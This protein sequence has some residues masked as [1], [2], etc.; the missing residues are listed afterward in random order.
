M[1]IYR[2]QYIAAG[3][4]LVLT[5]ANKGSAQDVPALPVAPRTSAFEVDRPPVYPPA[6]IPKPPIVFVPPN[7]PQP[8]WMPSPLD[9][10]A[11]ARLQPKFVEHKSRSW[12]WR[13]FQGKVGGYP[14][15]F[16][17]RPFGSSLH[18]HGRMMV[19][20]GAAARLVL[21]NYDFVEGTS[22]LSPRGREQLA[23]V[24]LQLV[25]CPYPLL[26]ERTPESPGLAEARRASVLNELAAGPYPIDP[27]RVL[28]GLPSPRGLSGAEATIITANQLNRTQQYGPPIPIISNGLNSPSG[29]TNNVSGTLPGQ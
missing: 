4:A 8:G 19:A 29:V 27:G 1:S 5:T 21:F 2:F 20:N 18:E 6:V 9:P 13:R 10:V 3:F 22:Q 25:A 14:E 12:L 23:K 16:A 7:G 17:P 26:I 28:V 24:S 15:E 11:E